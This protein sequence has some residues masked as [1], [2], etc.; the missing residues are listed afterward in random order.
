MRSTTRF[1]YSR[2]GLD[3]GCPS[4]DAAALVEVSA[5]TVR[6]HVI[7]ETIALL[8]NPAAPRVSVGLDQQNDSPPN[9]TARGQIYEHP[10]YIF[11]LSY[12]Q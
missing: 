1:K 4:A 9:R 5:I 11:R 3:G 12:A 10:S 6:R 7:S 2:R 8:E